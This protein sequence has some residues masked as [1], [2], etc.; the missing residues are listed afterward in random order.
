MNI[1]IYLNI[2]KDTGKKLETGKI[3]AVNSLLL[4]CFVISVLVSWGCI[5]NEELQRAILKSCYSEINR[6]FYLPGGSWDFNSPNCTPSRYFKRIP[7]YTVSLLCTYTDKMSLVC[8]KSIMKI[9][10]DTKLTRMIPRVLNLIPVYQSL[11]FAD[12]HCD[13]LRLKLL[14]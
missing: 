11:E 5:F 10:L 1:G 9:R 14:F 7:S 2:V 6:T 3:F 4:L 12:S 13:S 8:L